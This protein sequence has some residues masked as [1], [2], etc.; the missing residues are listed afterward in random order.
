MASSL[1]FLSNA[2]AFVEVYR[3]LITSEDFAQITSDVQKHGWTEYTRKLIHNFVRQRTDS[4]WLPIVNDEVS[5]KL[6]DNKKFTTEVRLNLFVGKLVN[7]YYEHIVSLSQ[8][9]GIEMKSDDVNTILTNI[10]VPIT[11]YIVENISTKLLFSIDP[12]SRTIVLKPDQDL[13]AEIV[14]KLVVELFVTDAH[15]FMVDSVTPIFEN[16]SAENV[17]SVFS[18]IERAFKVVN[19]Y[20]KGCQESSTDNDTNTGSKRKR[21]DDDESDPKRKK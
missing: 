7:K 2:F 17:S 6:L 12:T 4:V 20:S 16:I 19:E 3:K 5:K 8:T 14:H 9:R 10:I 1:S 21:D 18:E 13:D 15:R 11:N